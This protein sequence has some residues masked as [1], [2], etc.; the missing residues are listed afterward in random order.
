MPYASPE[1]KLANERRYSHR[2]RMRR[3]ERRAWAGFYVVTRRDVRRLLHRYNG[4][5]AYCGQ[6]DDM[7]GLDHVFPLARGGQHRIGNLLPACP[8]CNARKG[9]ATLME[10]H[11][12]ELW[13][14]RIGY[15][16]KF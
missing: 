6:R 11:K 10:W 15:D 16:E 3:Q 5:C 9:N 2:R 8:S 14:I 13:K 12:Y 4:R 7:L 1:A